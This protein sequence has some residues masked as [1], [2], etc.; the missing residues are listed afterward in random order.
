MR[1]LLGAAAPLLEQRSTATRRALDVVQ[2]TALIFLL[3]MVLLSATACAQQ[4]EEGA[5]ASAG[6]SAPESTA[7]VEAPSASDVSDTPAA[8]TAATGE[9][10]EASSSASSQK[11][12]P[13]PAPGVSAT[14]AA[15]SSGKGAASDAASEEEVDIDALFE[16]LDVTEDY[17]KS[18]VHGEKPADYQRYIVLHDTEGGDSAAN[19]IDWWD[20]NGNL[21]AA[22]FIVNKDGSIWQCV[23][24]DKIA[25]HAGFGD[26]GHNVEFGTNNEAR[27]DKKG[28]TPIGDDYADYGMNSYSIGIE[29]VHQGGEGDYPE[30][31]LEA[32]DKLIAYID[33]Y[34]GFESQIIDHKAW[35]SGNSDTSE[36]FAPYLKSY[37]QKRTHA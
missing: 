32:V 21:I 23:P 7:A 1:N 24:L 11:E 16:D 2:I 3:L 6:S 19:V 8:T 4:S 30:A 33:A 31:Q 13:D 15:A 10:A 14:D 28:T 29:M 9:D 35:R 22:H 37:Q 5:D 17:R 12:S 26:T 34:Y 18:F 20:S 27:D 36:E 25:H